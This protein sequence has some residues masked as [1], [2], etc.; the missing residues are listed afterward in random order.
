MGAGRL[1]VW[2]F[3]NVC[4]RPPN[5]SPFL[6]RWPLAQVY[7]TY[8]D[9]AGYVDK[10]CFLRT[11]AALGLEVYH[12]PDGVLCS[13]GWCLEVDVTEKMLGSYSTLE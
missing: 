1:E 6:F 4:V 10:P 5:V 13:D 8:C 12:N 9:E 3:R 7:R 11:L 2:I